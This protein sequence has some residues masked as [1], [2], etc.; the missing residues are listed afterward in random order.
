MSERALPP[1]YGD[2]LRGWHVELFGSFP[3]SGDFV[4]RLDFAKPPSLGGSV[5]DGPCG[6]LRELRLAL[7]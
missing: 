7:R 4:G 6:G 3:D 1:L 2:Q 5:V